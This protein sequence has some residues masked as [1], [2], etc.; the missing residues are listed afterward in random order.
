MG[1]GEVAQSVVKSCVAQISIHGL[2]HA[3]GESNSRVTAL[4][5]IDLDIDTEA[6][7]SPSSGR[8]G[9]ASQPCSA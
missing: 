4:T 1:G 9:A 8:A 6:S 2:T 7:S 5:D 3:Y